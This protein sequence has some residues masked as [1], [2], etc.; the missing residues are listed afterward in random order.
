MER[1]PSDWTL[2][3]EEDAILYDLALQEERARELEGVRE[4]IQ[5]V[6]LEDTEEQVG[7][8]GTVSPPPSP[9]GSPQ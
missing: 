2:N 6:S 9:P 5:S 3:G 8:R 1:S 7:F 4:R